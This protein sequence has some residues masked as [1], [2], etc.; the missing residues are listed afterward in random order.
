[1]LGLNHPKTNRSWGATSIA[2]CPP[3]ED[4]HLG[5]EE[6][7]LDANRGQRTGAGRP[8]RISP[9][10]E[11]LEQARDNDSHGALHSAERFPAAG[12]AQARQLLYWASGCQMVAMAVL[13][14]E[15]SR[16]FQLN[17]TL[18]EENGGCGFVLKPECLRNP[19][20]DVDYK[21]WTIPGV[22]SVRL[23]V[24]V[25]S[26][27][28]LSTLGAH[29]AMKALSTQVQVDLYNSFNDTCVGKRRNRTALV[30]HNSV[31]PRYVDSPAKRTVFVFEKVDGR[32]WQ[33]Y[34]SVQV[35]KPEGAFVHFTVITSGGK[36]IGQR[37]LPVHRIRQGTVGAY[38]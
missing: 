20:V 11:Q 4:P 35:I 7:T 25:L 38:P 6:E 33:G 5:Q 27:V 17:Q 16:P 23:E 31:N 9:A 37:F 26:A 32:D 12:E 28:F 24:E 21:G 18:F 8:L 15:A 30:R 34:D 19:N 1:M 2:E 14:P 36:E 3:K 13:H 29:K 10:G 22:R